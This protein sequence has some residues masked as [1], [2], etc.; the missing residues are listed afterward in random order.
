LCMC[1]NARVT[2]GG[3]DAGFETL[4][5]ITK[6]IKN[7]GGLTGR[8][9]NGAYRKTRGLQAMRWG[10]DKGRCK[11]CWS[12]EASV[13]FLSVPTGVG[14]KKRL[15]T[16]R[17]FNRAKTRKNRPKATAARAQKSHGGQNKKQVKSNKDTQ[18]QR[19][20]SEILSR[21]YKTARAKRT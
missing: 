12:T 10:D 16:G 20:G 15:T 18:K 9:C 21:P 2:G 19:G 3:G 17:C 14:M 6:T 11:S 4:R 1:G 8:N 7:R 5:S 13:F